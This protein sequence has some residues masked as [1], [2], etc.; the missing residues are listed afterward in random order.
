MTVYG[1]RINVHPDRYGAR[2]TNP[3]R[4]LVIHT[5]EGSEGQASAE[6]LGAYMTMPGDRPGSNGPYGSSYQYVTDTDRVLPATPD[7]VVSYSAAGANHDGIHICI[8][9]R[10][11]QTRAQWL[12][13]VS[14]AYIYQ[15]AC[16]MVDKAAEHD[17]PLTRLTV[18]QVRDGARGY[19]GHHDVSL[20]FGKSTHTDPGA[21][22]P[23][24]VLADDIASL[25]EDDMQYV[26]DLRR[27]IDTRNLGG[28]VQPGQV[29]TVGVKAPGVAA[30]VNITVAEA[31]SA[32]FLTAWG[33]GAQPATSN[34]NYGT[35]AP[36]VANTARV[37]IDPNGN[38]IR[39]TVANAPCHVIVDLQGV[40][41]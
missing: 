2:K 7:D 3:N 34:V 8:P 27:L 33:T 1:P 13:P 39:F 41:R 29:V 38:V 4:L 26:P 16:V 15:A 24:D 25:T 31:E 23:W 21:Q 10:A 36:V 35:W 22:F 9:G 28:K 40:I 20:A 17:I 6:N 18:A 14:R 30:D 12:D 11:N 19:C 37:P 5:S 32:G